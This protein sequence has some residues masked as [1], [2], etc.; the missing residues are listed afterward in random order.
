MRPSRLPPHARK[1]CCAASKE[2]SAGSATAAPALGLD[3]K[4]LIDGLGLDPELVR[5]AL[6]AISD[7]ELQALGESAVP[8]QGLTLIDLAC[9]TSLHGVRGSLGLNDQLVSRV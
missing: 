7:A 4:A 2:R 1:V 3:A 8:W 9:G 6:S 5:A